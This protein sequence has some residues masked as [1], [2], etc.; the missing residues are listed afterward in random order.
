MSAFDIHGQYDNLK[1]AVTNSI[2]DV[3][4]LETDKYKLQLHAVNV[5]DSVS[6]SDYKSQK[7][8]KLK[9]QTWAVPVYANMSV[10]DKETGKVVSKAD[11]VRVMN[12]PKVTDRGSY[13]I[14]GNEYQVVN[15][16]RLKP[17]VY[18]ASTKAGDVKAQINLAKGGVGKNL[19]IELDG[20]RLMLTA[21]QANIPL[22]DLL[23]GL[24][25]S[26]TAIKEQWGNKATD[27]Q[28]EKYDPTHG[29]KAVERFQQAFTSG[30]PALTF[31]ERRTAIDPISTKAMVGKLASSS[32]SRTARSLWLT[33]IVSST[34]A[35]TEW[36]TLCRSA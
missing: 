1:N 2:K 36:K 28:A 6:S 13:I 27:I 17:G 30:E 32:V 23:R 12:L 4:K 19:G 10:V 31:M 7:D 5:D 26:H 3:L 24:G 16:L 34:K 15:Q 9:G 33:V 22:Y 25:M 14:N 35:Y 20:D 18:M 11:K 29:A 8:A 21:R